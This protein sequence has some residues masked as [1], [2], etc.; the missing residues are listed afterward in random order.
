MSATYHSPAQQIFNKR[1]IRFWGFFLIVLHLNLLIM[2]VPWVAPVSK[3]LLRHGRSSNP[4]SCNK[5]KSTYGQYICSTVSLNRR[6]RRPY[7]YDII[8]RVYTKHLYFPSSSNS[9]GT[10]TTWFHL[11]SLFIKSKYYRRRIQSNHSKLILIEWNP[12]ESNEIKRN[13]FKSNQI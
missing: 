4:P 2:F 3:T 9:T 11:A 5:T 1:Q 10:Q 6:R 8:A 13:Q 12:I 7:G